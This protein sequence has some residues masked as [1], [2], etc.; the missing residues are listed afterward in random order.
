MQRPFRHIVAIVIALLVLAM[1]APAP[2]YAES[3]DEDQRDDV[4]TRRGEA[5]AQLNALEVSDE[6]LER[7][8]AELD[9]RLQVVQAD[10]DDAW[11]AAEA[12]NAAAA[13]ALRRRRRLEHGIARLRKIVFDRAV[14][15]YMDPQGD[16][17]ADI[18]MAR[19]LDE[20]TRRRAL[21]EMV[22]SG[23]GDAIDRLRVAQEDL[24]IAKHDA[25]EA[26]QQAAKRR[27][28]AE[29]RVAEVERARGKKAKTAAALDKRIHRFQDEV[30]A[31]ARQEVALTSKILEATG[32]SG[33]SL[34][35]SATGLIWPVSG[36]VTSEYGYRWGRNH[37]GLDISASTGT[38]IRASKEGVVI[39][40]GSEG[41]YGYTVIIDHG[42]GFT[43]LYAHQSSIAASSGET[44][45]QGE[46]I[47]Y[48]GCTGSCTGPH[49]HFETR[50]NGGAQDPRRYLS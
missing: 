26:K 24:L 41:G 39:S 30:D 29:K 11:R 1:A 15:V 38:A 36:T 9:Q 47:G 18:V 34:S 2:A 42:G 23:D 44:V 3:S 19:D 48:V 8:L 4:R 32:V 22:T 25:F 7:A 50:V 16:P 45:S 40:S 12:A 17:M 28:Q 33:I 31:L 14:A 35:V 21:L 49:L 27:R 46:I 37:N 20:A 43:T 10:A 13:A 5:E 6:E